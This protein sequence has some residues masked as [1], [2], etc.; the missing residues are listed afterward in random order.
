MGPQTFSTELVRVAIVARHRKYLYPLS[1]ESVERMCRQGNFKTAVKLGAGRRA[2][3]W[4]SPIE[5]L[6]WKVSRHA[7]QLQE[8]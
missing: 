2:H 1:L 6:S 8:Y 5:V 4:V 3:W 7:T